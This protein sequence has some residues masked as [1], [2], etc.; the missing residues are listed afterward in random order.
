MEIIHLED[1]S[2]PDI[3]ERLKHENVQYK[4]VSP[5]GGALVILSEETYDN[6]LVTLECL[7]TPG[8]LDSISKDIST[9]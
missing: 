7:A 1:A 6:L 9:E 5:H 4:V 8:L 2:L 3:L